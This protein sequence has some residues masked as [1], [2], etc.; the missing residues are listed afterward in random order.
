MCRN[1]SHH[2]RLAVTPGLRHPN[3]TSRSV[4]SRP[5]NDA[6]ATNSKHAKFCGHPAR[7][8]QLL[9]KLNCMAAYIAPSLSR[10]TVSPS[11]ALTNQKA[12]W[13]RSI[14][15]RG[16]GRTGRHRPV[17]YD[18]DPRSNMDFDNRSSPATATPLLSQ[19]QHRGKTVHWPG[20]ARWGVELGGGFSLAQPDLGAPSQ[21]SRRR[22]RW[23]RL[24]YA[25]EVP[26]RRTRQ[27]PSKA[28]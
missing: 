6:P 18:R 21:S 12:R 23:Q 11:M 28:S 1:D 22:L 10:R 25:T 5:R 24:P 17:S 20:K 27:L 8:Y 16:L 9:P 7:P 15:L 3:P 4:A 26:G 14:K 13:R 2:R 19:S